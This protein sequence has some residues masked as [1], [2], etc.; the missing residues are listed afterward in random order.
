M[1]T[2]VDVRRSVMVAPLDDYEAQIGDTQW[3][4]CGWDNEDA[5]AL[6]DAIRL[7]ET[8]RLMT[9]SPKDVIVFDVGNVTWNVSP[10]FTRA[11]GLEGEGPTP[12]WVMAGND[13]PRYA[14]CHLEGAT[15]GA[16]ADAVRAALARAEDLGPEGMADLAPSNGWG[17]HACVIRI[18]GA[19]V[20][21]L[22]EC[23]PTDT[24]ALR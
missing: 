13:R 16:T 21:A 17:S 9:P 12:L 20:R 3:Q 23:E 7:G 6:V 15:L 11:F 5:Q 14:L 4:E 22:N 24:W 1:S 2:D 19:M 8:A 18:L 10:M